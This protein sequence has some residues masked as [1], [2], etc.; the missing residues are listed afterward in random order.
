MSSSRKS[1]SQIWTVFHDSFVPHLERK[2][3]FSEF[4]RKYLSIMILLRVELSLK[5]VDLN[6]QKIHKNFGKKGEFSPKKRQNFSQKNVFVSLKNINFRF[7]LPKKRTN[8]DLDDVRKF[9]QN[10]KK[11]DKHFPKKCLFS[12]W[13][14]WIFE[15]IFEKNKL[16]STMM[17]WGN[18]IK[19]ITNWSKNFKKMYVFLF[20]NL[21]FSCYSS[22]KWN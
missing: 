20:E 4:E 21:P 12:L 13:K 16:I 9:F 5:K 10:H 1:V 18:F 8:V 3:Q 22:K 11:F 2:D 17:M 19:I 14:S 7:V 6:H 15:S